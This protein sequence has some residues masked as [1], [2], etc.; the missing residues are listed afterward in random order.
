MAAVGFGITAIL[1]TTGKFLNGN[2]Y[3][4]QPTARDLN[5]T[6]R[7]QLVRGRCEPHVTRAAP[8]TSGVF[9]A[10]QENLSRAVLDRVLERL[11]HS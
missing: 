1:F 6:G 4:Q 10:E 5:S 7:S 2:L 8:E 3:R 9:G 11:V